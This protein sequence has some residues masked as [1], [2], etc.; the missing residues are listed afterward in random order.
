MEY[1]KTKSEE[2]KLSRDFRRRLEDDEVEVLARALLDKDEE[3]EMDDARLVDWTGVVGKYQSCWLGEPEPEA[4][5]VDDDEDGRGIIFRCQFAIVA[6]LC[7]MRTR[8]AE[9]E[10]CEC[11]GCWLLGAHDGL[12]LTA[13]CAAF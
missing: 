4:E 10:N 9:N 3:R 8:E 12:K 13:M 2:L 1:P 7:R 6:D 5:P 11:I